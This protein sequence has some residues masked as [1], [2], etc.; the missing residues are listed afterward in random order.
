VNG[1]AIWIVSAQH[2]PR[3]YLRA[4][5]IER[6]FDAVGYA[7]LS[8]ALAALDTPGAALPALIVLELCDLSLTRNESDVLAQ[9]NIP[10]VLLGGAAELRSDLVEGFARAATL[11]RPYTVGQVADLLQNLMT[12]GA[13]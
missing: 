7:N 2:W 13:D 9:A 11:Q 3:A 6:G 10:V 12:R 5:L 8:T 1:P 4:E